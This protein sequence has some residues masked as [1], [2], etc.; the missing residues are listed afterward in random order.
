MK[1][2][3][4]TTTEQLIAPQET[5]ERINTFLKTHAVGVISTCDQD[6]NP[7]GAVIYL[8]VD[9][10]FVMTFVTKDETKKHQNLQANPKVMFVTH[11]ASSQ[12]TVQVRGIA[13]LIDNQQDQDA[14]FAAISSLSSDQLPITKLEAGGFVAY[15][16]I[17]EE[18]RMAIF[19]R[20][21]PGG[22][23][24][25]ETIYFEPVAS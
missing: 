18:I 17:P 1:Q 15:Q 8:T 14:V 10:N 24:M 22:Y 4:E 16:L 7:H 23:D 25:Y 11:E 19:T 9:D 6:N 12:T 21:D 13:Q 20:P 3:Q 5:K 2:P